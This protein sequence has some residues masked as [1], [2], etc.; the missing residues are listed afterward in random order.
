MNQLRQRQ[1]K[2]KDAVNLRAYAQNKPCMI[3]IP[4]ICTHDPEKTVLAHF[5]MLPYCGGSL[6]P[7]DAVAA[8]ADG[9]CH[10]AVDGRLK[11]DYTEDELHRFFADGVIR[12]VAELRGAGI[13]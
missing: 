5:R 8:W 3:R 1:P 13:L 10:D 9:P 6:K 12:T 4:G 11:T 7:D 2:R